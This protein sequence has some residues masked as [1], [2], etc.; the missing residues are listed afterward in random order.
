MELQPQPLE[1][2]FRVAQLKSQLKDLDRDELED[3]CGRLLEVSSKL[4]HQTKQLMNYLIENER[5]RKN[6]ELP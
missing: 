1:E 6:F 5:S 4:T 3:Y 2:Q